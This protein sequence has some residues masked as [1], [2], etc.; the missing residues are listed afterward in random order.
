MRGC[1]GGRALSGVAL[2]N[3]RRRSILQGVGGD[4][5]GQMIEDN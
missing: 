1:D 2:A 3:E 4:A 5:V